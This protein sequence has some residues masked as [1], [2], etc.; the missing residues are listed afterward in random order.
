M[1]IFSQ[2]EQAIL[3]PSITSPVP[4]DYQDAVMEA[5]MCRRTQ[6]DA[7]LMRLTA[8][9]EP[10]GNVAKQLV[11]AMRTGHKVLV[12][13]NGGS[14]AQAQ[15]FAAEFVGRF[16]RERA[17]Y[18]VLSLTTDTSALT[19]V[20]NDYGY[21]DVFA[22]QVSAFGQAG[23]VLLAFSTSGESENLVRAASVSRERQMTVIA[24]TGNRQSRLG[25]LA[26]VTVRVPSEDTA[27]AQELHM[28]VA[29]ILCDIAET[30]LTA[31]ESESG[32]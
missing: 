23:D 4:V 32:R 3:V 20:A 29:H 8:W 15:H 19:A 11:R 18:P 26:D 27:V 7:A 30:E 2:N 6:M 14:A 28:I 5:L 17:A 10:L 13:G 22:R 1:G 31:R 21:D 12:A 9:I 16:K 24:L 25:K